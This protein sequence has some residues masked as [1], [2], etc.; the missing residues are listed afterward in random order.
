MKSAYVRSYWVSSEIRDGC[1]LPS[2]GEGWNLISRSFLSCVRLFCKLR[3]WRTDLYRIPPLLMLLVF[4]TGHSLPHDVRVCPF[5]LRCADVLRCFFTVAILRRWYR[6][7]TA[8]S[9]S[10]TL[11]VPAVAGKTQLFEVLQLKGTPYKFVVYAG[12]ADSARVSVVPP[13]LQT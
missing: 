11:W 3:K 13:T 8:T 4:L 9:T 5:C 7:L 1:D 6:T 10:R 2:L 12:L